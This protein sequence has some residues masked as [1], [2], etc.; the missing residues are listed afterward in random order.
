MVLERA[1]RGDRLEKRYAAPPAP[2]RFT[3]KKAGGIDA[4]LCLR[5]GRSVRGGGTDRADYHDL[6]ASPAPA[7]LLKDYIGMNGHSWSMTPHVSL[8]TPVTSLVRDYHPMDWDISHDERHHPNSLW[9]QPTGRTGI[10]NMAHG[11]PPACA[12]TWIF[13]SR[14]SA[15]TEWSNM[16]ADSYKYGKSV[17]QYFGAAGTGAGPDRIRG[18]RQRTGQL[19][20]TRTS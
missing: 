16:A 5:Q 1:G 4:L 6:P 11:R 18:D 2:K 14:T 9:A 13:S 15:Q 17:G 12:P 3:E 8:Y 10:R 7:P 19:L 20:A